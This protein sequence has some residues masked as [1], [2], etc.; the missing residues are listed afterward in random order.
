M[1]Q[2]NGIN[3][4]V[5]S[6]L[7]KIYRTI[8]LKR[9]LYSFIQPVFSPRK[10]IY[11]HLHFEG[12]ISIKAEPGKSFTMMHYGFEVENDLFWAG[13][14]NGWEKTSLRLWYELCKDSDTIL[15]VGAN[16]GV[17]ALLA[18]TTNPR[19]D[20]YA[21]E[22]VNRVYAKL[23]TNVELNGYDITCVKKA[24]SNA[25]GTAI[26]YDTSRPH[27]YS[28]TVNVNRMNQP[29]AFPVEIE[30]ITLDTF[31]K[32][33]GLSSVDLMKI[34]VETH[35]AEVLEGFSAHLRLSRPTLLV[36]ILNDEVAQR[37]AEVVGEIDYLYFNI[38]ETEGV[39]QSDQLSESNSRN[40]LICTR[41]T[42]LNQGLIHDR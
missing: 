2:S 29:D 27:T 1:L 4:T 6:I 33:Y 20:V 13:L 22:P 18:K 14:F 9:E 21:F 3:M 12:P 31:V 37:V 15:D 41:E 39:T 28:V 30:T 32:E 34:D 23:L 19:A 38:D 11:Q 16:T 35:E 40:F 5:R 36:E 10:S 24:A 8:P 42:A 17:Y 26:I 25:D 7:K